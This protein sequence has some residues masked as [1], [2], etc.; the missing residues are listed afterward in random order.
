MKN[1]FK[2]SSRN[3]LR[4]N[5]FLIRNFI[6]LILSC[7]VIAYII[8]PFYNWINKLFRNPKISAIISIIIIF[9]LA[10]GLL[11]FIINSVYY[12]V[13]NYGSPL[14]LQFI[15]F[16]SYLNEINSSNLLIDL[17]NDVTKQ[18]FDLIYKKNEYAFKSRSPR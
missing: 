14:I 8:K 5:P 4:L 6:T 16:D 15:D 2:N 13:T 9:S 1:P 18:A 11:V 12:Q 10:A 7:I 17:N 3:F